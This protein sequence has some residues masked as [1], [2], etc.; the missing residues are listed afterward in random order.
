MCAR[1]GKVKI[2]VAG[3]TIVRA[4][5]A[6]LEEIVAETKGGAFGKVQ[7]VKVL[8]WHESL[9]SHDALV[10]PRQTKRLQRAHDQLAGLLLQRRPVLRMS[11]AEVTDGD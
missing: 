11:G 4:Q 6:D 3:M 5:V 10:R 1:S 9:L 2:A 7:I 8:L